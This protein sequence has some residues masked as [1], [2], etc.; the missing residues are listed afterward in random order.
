MF[1]TTKGPSNKYQAPY[2]NRVCLQMFIELL[3]YFIRYTRV[4]SIVG[5]CKHYYSFLACID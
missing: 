3:L 4:F 1:R 5:L 2:D